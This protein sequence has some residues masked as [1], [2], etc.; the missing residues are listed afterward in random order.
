MANIL[1]YILWRGDLSFLQDDFNEIDNLILARLSYFPFDHILKEEEIDTL[2]N[3]YQKFCFLDW[4][5]EKILQKEDLDLFPALANS[6]R[7]GKL[8]IGYYQNT[9][10]PEDEKQFSAI[11]I[12]LPNNTMVLS[13]RG[14]DN[15][16]IGWKD[17]FN[18]SFK[19]HVASQLDAID[20][21][22]KIARKISRQKDSHNR[23]FKRRK[24]SNLRAN[25]CH[26]KSTR[27]YFENL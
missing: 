21:L 3:L 27:S 12:F 25:L 16:I 2:E 19:S 23:S 10:S 22:E 13:Y 18:M 20:Y 8:E 9:I 17:D 24:F 15:T 5:K 14:T 11:T 1:D 7:F 26:K 6:R 4:E